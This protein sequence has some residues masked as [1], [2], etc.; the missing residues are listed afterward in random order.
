MQSKL[1]LWTVEL[2]IYPAFNV[3]LEISFV[4]TVK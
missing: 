4:T 1:I 3:Q 2:R